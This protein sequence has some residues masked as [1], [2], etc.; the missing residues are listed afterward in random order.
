[1]HRRAKYTSELPGLS[2]V[3]PRRSMDA[4]FSAKIRKSQPPPF[5]KVRLEPQPKFA[6]P[7]VGPLLHRWRGTV[8]HRTVSMISC[9][10]VG[11]AERR[12]L[13]CQEKSI[14][15][16]SWSLSAAIS[17]REEKKSSFISKARLE[18]QP[19]FAVPWVGPL[20]HR[21]RG[22]V[23]HRTVSMI[24]CPTVGVAERRLLTCQEKSIIQDS[25]SLSA[26]I[27]SREEKK[28][29]F[30]SEEGTRNHRTPNRRLRNTYRP[31]LGRLSC[32]VTSTA[33][34]RA[35]PA[36]PGS[37]P[38]PSSS[39]WDRRSLSC[40]SATVSPVNCARFACPCAPL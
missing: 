8:S 32:R 16:D 2:H 11:V 25:W 13:T 7:W 30:I 5:S 27:S 22:T 9:P 18:P 39:W 3:R 35:A 28:S 24:A 21:W 40:L 1:M 38:E 20:L 31:K 29:S 26:A 4:D 10:T 6:V 17:S 23:S 37:A 12:L 19:K 36:S 14:I 34:H 33:K 15:Q